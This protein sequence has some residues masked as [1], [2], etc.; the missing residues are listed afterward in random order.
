[1]NPAQSSHPDRVRTGRRHAMALAVCL[2]T[3]TTAPVLAGSGVITPNPFDFGNIIVGQTSAVQV[4]TLNNPVAETLTI[5]SA[6]LGGSAPGQYTLVASTC[7]GAIPASGSCTM[8]VRFSPS[9]TGSHVAL[10]RVVYTSPS[11]PPGGTEVTATLFGN[12]TAAPLQPA[13]PVPGAGGIAL[14]VLTLL[15]LGAGLLTLRRRAA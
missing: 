12:A 6:G 3:F 13:T 14:A 10:V 9:A 4:F 5:T 15:S 11:A 8:S 7:A 2:L 1:M